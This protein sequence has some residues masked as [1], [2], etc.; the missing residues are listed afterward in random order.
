[1]S[2]TANVAMLEDQCLSA[3]SWNVAAV[4]NN[5]FEYWIQ[6]FDDSYDCFM[7]LVEE[8]MQ[9]DSK[10][11]PVFQIFTDTMFDEL[12]HELSVINADKVGNLEA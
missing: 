10:D 7:R 2:Q 4:N 12:L 3:V 1:M 5:P 9:D 8:F 6:Y 11:F